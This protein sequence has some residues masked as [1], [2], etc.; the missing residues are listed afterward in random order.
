MI[1]INYV[2]LQWEERRSHREA[3]VLKGSW[4]VWCCTVVV[5]S[6]SIWLTV[7]SWNPDFAPGPAINL[8][9]GIS[10]VWQCD[11]HSPWL[12]FPLCK[13]EFIH[14]KPGEAVFSPGS[15]AG[16]FCGVCSEHLEAA[17]R[18]LLQIQLQ[19]IQV[20]SASHPPPSA[21]AGRAGVKGWTE[22]RRW[23]FK[24]LV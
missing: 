21:G 13:T 4:A 6:T 9:S 2:E 19:G 5:G 3:R 16:C 23:D 14:P 12:E 10:H 18:G 24:A 17:Q 7:Q 11:R 15:V 20:T 1:G 22:N 8:W